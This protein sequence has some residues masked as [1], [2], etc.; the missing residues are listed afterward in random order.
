M[1][2][3]DTL[4]TSR[5]CL[6]RKCIE[7]TNENL[8]IYTLAFKSLTIKFQPYC[9]EEV[10]RLSNSRRKGKKRDPGYEAIPKKDKNYGGGRE[11]GSLPRRHS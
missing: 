7:T 1:N 5:H 4:T 3:A 8:N 11:R 2:L 6:G 10:L 9:P